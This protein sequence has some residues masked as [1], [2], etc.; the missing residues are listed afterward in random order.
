MRTP[1]Y[2]CWFITPLTGSLYPPYIIVNQGNCPYIYIYIHNCFVI[3]PPK[4]T[5][6]P[7]LVGGL[8]H[9]LFFH[10]LTAGLSVRPVA[11]QY[12]AIKS[13]IFQRG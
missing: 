12:R 5:S 2:V 9:F 7:R 4:K 10:I 6:I 13:N 1:S 11:P 8:V 3:F